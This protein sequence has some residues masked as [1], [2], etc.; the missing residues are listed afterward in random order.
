V[1][2]AVDTDEDEDEVACLLSDASPNLKI[3]DRRPRLFLG[4]NPTLELQE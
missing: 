2:K 3:G 1:S 4:D